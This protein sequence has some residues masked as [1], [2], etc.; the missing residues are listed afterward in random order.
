MC[1]YLDIVCHNSIALLLASLQPDSHLT[2]LNSKV[3]S[4]KLSGSPGRLMA[5]CEVRTYVHTRMHKQ[6]IDYCLVFKCFMHVYGAIFDHECLYST[7]IMYPLNGVVQLLSL[8]YGTTSPHRMAG[9]VWCVQT[10]GR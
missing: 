10:A 3:T 6:S 8:H 7:L 9:F 5:M 4:L 1:V 2:A